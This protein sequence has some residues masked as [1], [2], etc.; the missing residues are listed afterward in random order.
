MIFAVFVPSLMG[1]GILASGAILLADLLRRHLPQR[2]LHRR[3]RVAMG[4]FRVVSAAAAWADRDVSPG[5][6]LERAP[7]HRATYL[8]WA[9]GCGAA[10]VILPKAALAA[11]RDELGLFY[12]SPWM[13]G[14]GAGAAVIF[15][16]AAILLLIVAA[17]S[18]RPP[19]PVAWLVART[20]LGRLQVPDPLPFEDPPEGASCEER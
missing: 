11:F 17:V 19:R 8:V 12:S 1:V 13:I 7:R 6:L 9:V 14:W 18:T 5:E 20:A 4:T 16:L 10:A 3:H 2:R 15:G